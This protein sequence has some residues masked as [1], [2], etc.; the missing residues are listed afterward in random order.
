MQSQPLRSVLIGSIMLNRDNKV[1]VQLVQYST[2]WIIDIRVWFV[3]D[4]GELKPS[5][6]G[7]GFSIDHVCELAKY[8]RKARKRAERK[9]LL[10]KKK[11]K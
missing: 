2:R 11:A 5:R 4:D 7:I 10:P 8:V 9:G 6:R 3:N 1:F